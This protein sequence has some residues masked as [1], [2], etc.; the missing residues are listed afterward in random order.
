MN[1][2][3]N[4]QENYNGPELVIDPN[5]WYE[6]FRNLNSVKSKFDER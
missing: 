1:S 2:L 6:H 3:K 4:E 5:T